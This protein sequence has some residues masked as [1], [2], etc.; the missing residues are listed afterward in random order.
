MMNTPDQPTDSPGRQMFGQFIQQESAS[1]DDL[2]QP[3][4]FSLDMHAMHVGARFHD[5]VLGHGQLAAQA[6]HSGLMVSGLQAGLQ[7]DMVRTNS[8]IEAPP[9]CLVLE[10]MM[11]GHVQWTDRHGVRHRSGTHGEIWCF[12][13]LPDWREYTMLPGQLSQAHITADPALLARWLEDLPRGQERQ[14]LEQY[15]DAMARGTP[16]MLT[17]AM[18]AA[19]AGMAAHLQTQLQ[20]CLHLP[21]LSQRLQI[22]GLATSL[23]G[24][25]LGLPVS[26]PAPQRPRWERA[27]QAAI[28][29]IHAEYGG[30]HLSIGELARRTGTN[31]CYLKRGFRERTGTSI[32]AY[33]RQL[34]LRSA[35]A[36]LEENRLSIR[37][38][39]REVGYAS[40]SQ[41][42]RAFRALHGFSPS[43]VQRQR[44]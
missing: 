44:A 9:P 40:P 36:L 10:L 1:T 33:I 24:A 39:A 27:V 15:L 34:R 41:F 4:A 29:I 26:A 17:T 32:A 12:S 25:W 31:E 6:F 14:H 5:H 3:D 18:P 21:T 37:E 19:M 13:G 22:E 30:D 28:D 8:V 16:R 38:V 2:P 20:D 23:L 11:G 7:H 43:D 35:L 42:A